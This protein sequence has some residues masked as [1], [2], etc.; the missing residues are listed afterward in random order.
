MNPV[1]D[2]EQILRAREMVRQV[3]I[4]EKIKNYVLNLVLTT[5]NGRPIYLEDVATV[6]DTYEDRQSRAAGTRLSITGLPSATR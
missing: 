2:P 4:D 6:R 3:Y 1:I 5:R